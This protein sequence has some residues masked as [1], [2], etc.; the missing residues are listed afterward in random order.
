MATPR[1]APSYENQ[2]AQRRALIN[3]GPVTRALQ[4]ELDALRASAKDRLTTLAQPTI[5]LLA[6][7]GTAV[8]V[9]ARS[10]ARVQR[11]LAQQD[12]QLQGSAALVAAERF[13]ANPPRTAGERRQQE[14]TILDKVRADATRRLVSQLGAEFAN[15][16]KGAASGILEKAKALEDAVA[17]ERLK[18]LGIGD[19]AEASLEDILRRQELIVDLESRATGELAEWWHGLL[20]LDPAQARRIEPALIRVLRSRSERTWARSR[21]PVGRT[22]T[23]RSDGTAIPH[24]PEYKAESEML[25][26]RKLLGEVEAGR[27][28]RRSPDL[29]IFD[30]EFRPQIAALLRRTIGVDPRELDRVA[31]EEYARTMRTGARLDELP[32]RLDWPFRAVVP[33]SP[34]ARRA[35]PAKLDG[36][37]AQ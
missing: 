2:Q 13:G 10:G 23:T 17:R 33:L 8:S 21:S 15:E 12:A 19:D 3:A 24:M 4:E 37:G 35:M 22:G 6:A 36:E 20:R 25:A 34:V 16:G 5:N 26:A 11:G 28:L 18:A 32:L 31:F 30:S 9:M 7:M 14:E 1:M 27:Q 29:D